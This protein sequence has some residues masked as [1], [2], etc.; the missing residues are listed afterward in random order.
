MFSYP[1]QVIIGDISPYTQAI[2]ILNQTVFGTNWT[3]NAGSDVIVYQTPAGQAPDDVTQILQTSQYSVAF[4]GA[5]QQVQVTLVTPAGAGDIITITRQTPA[6]RENLYT[7]TNFVPQ[8]L[9]NDFGILT[10]V[11]QQAQLVNQLIGPRYNYSAVITDVV[12]TILPILGPNEVWVKNANNTAIIA[13]DLG[14]AGTGTVSPGLQNE[15]AWYAATGDTVEGLP[16]GNNGVLVT[17]NTGAPSISS[18]L[19]L[20][21]QSNIT[22][23]GTQTQALNMG[24]N[25]INNVAT[26]VSADDAANKAY[27]DAIVGGLNPLLAVQAATTSNLNATYSNGTAGV[28]ATLT[29]AGSLLAFAVDGYS[30]S[31]GD[32]ILVKDQTTTYQNG[33]YTVTTVGSASVAWVLTR[34]TDYDT[35][36]QIQQ[37][38]WFPVENGT[39]NAGSSWIQTAVVVT[40]GTDA[41]TFSNFFS[42]TTYLKVA[43]NLSDLANRVTAINNLFNVVTG[44][45][46]LNQGGTNA[47]LTASNGGVVFSSASALQLLAGTATAGLALLSG[48]SGI[49][50]WST[51][52]PIT[53]TNLV[54]ITTTGT[55]TPS[56]GL[57][58]ALVECIG[59]G[60]AGA[61]AH[62][63]S[64]AG[65]GYGTGGGG[66]GERAIS[67]LSKATIGASQSVTIGA[68]GTGVAGNNNGNNGGDTSFGSLV[69]A[70]GGSGGQASGSTNSPGPGG[71]GG[72]GGTG[73]LLIDGQNGG[74]GSGANGV[75]N[76]YITGGKG[77]DSVY[78]QGGLAVWAGGTE[79][80]NGNAATGFGA[81][82]SGSAVLTATGNATGGN[83][84][85]GAI[86]ILEYISI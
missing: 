76:I 5:Q 54:V 65:V 27:V 32:R 55:Y 37:G 16:T 1:S 3:A 84:S 43:N 82:G 10:L 6:S 11:D 12:D 67:L 44:L 72:T 51:S 83:G 24:N 69:I 74:I 30:A 58:D 81:G 13:F 35:P 78:G 63:T 33:I 20:A 59:G 70:K 41:I 34:A 52:P 15:L 50:S 21:V 25:L 14:A 18:T 68:G 77:A 28:G 60:A 80:V 31:L 85:P 56:A 19:P 17:S 40:I 61:G 49:G 45:V 75:S 38:D 2:A 47:N 42:T 23:L 73:N 48:A 4:I 86:I 57:V 22:Q 29:N 46:P 36:T 39:V 26:P 53:K 71:A 62:T 66:G 7:N 79:L 9:N 8:M 64:G